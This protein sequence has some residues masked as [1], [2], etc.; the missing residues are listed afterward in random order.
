M[1]ARIKELAE[2]CKIAIRSI[3]RDSNKVIDNAE[4]EKEISEDDRDTMKESVQELTKK[5]EN[6]ATEL[7]KTREADVM[8]E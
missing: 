5:Y 2:E 1:V 7:A 8:E 6:E 3:R 4:K